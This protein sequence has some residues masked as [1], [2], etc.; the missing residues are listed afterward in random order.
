MFSRLGVESFSLLREN[1]L[2]NRYFLKA[3]KGNRLRFPLCLLCDATIILQ[4]LQ[5]ELLRQ[6]LRQQQLL[7]QPTI[8]LF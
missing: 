3:K 4:Q 7:E 8:Q 1:E 5:L 6:R 2:T